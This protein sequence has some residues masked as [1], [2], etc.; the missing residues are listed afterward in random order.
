MVTSIYDPLKCDDEILQLRRV[1][2]VSRDFGRPICTQVL[3]HF[4]L[5]YTEYI[6]MASSDFKPMFYPDVSQ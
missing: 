1:T 3:F 6:R 2:D 5:I 4:F